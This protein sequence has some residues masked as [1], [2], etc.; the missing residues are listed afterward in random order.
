MRKLRIKIF[1]FLT[2]VAFFLGCEQPAAPV[3]DNP[4]DPGGKNYKPPVA[5]ITSPVDSVSESD[6][7][8]FKW[9]NKSVSDEQQENSLFK[10]RI[11]I[12]GVVVDSSSDWTPAREKTYTGLNDVTYIFEVR[13][14]YKVDDPKA[15]TTEQKLP[16][17]KI[18][19]VKTI[20]SPGLYFSPREI[21]IT[22]TNK[23]F[24]VELFVA[25]EEDTIMGIHCVIEYDPASIEIT[26]NNIVYYDDNNSF[27]GKIGGQIVDI[28]A[29]VSGG[30]ITID[31]G[32]LS[33]GKDKPKGVIGRGAVAGITIKSLKKV[34]KTELKFSAQGNQLRDLDNQKI[35]LEFIRGCKIKIK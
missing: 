20:R 30:K 27:V 21:E 23:T 10:Y 12:G 8:T 17:Q 29:D 9:R 2:F 26:R 24:L 14:K 5:E 34:E 13:A 33:G 32:I 16:T 3:R 35:D 25:S 19:K 11:K 31:I 6:S 7:L 4:A 1:I 28:P 22:G 15:D 18:I